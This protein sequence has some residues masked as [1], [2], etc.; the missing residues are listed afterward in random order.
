MHNVTPAKIKWFQKEILKWYSQHGRH[1][2]WRN[3]N[4]T[5]YDKVIAEVLLQ[6]TKAETVQKFYTQFIIDYPNWKSLADADLKDIE[7]YLKP[8]GLYRQRAVRLHNLAVEMVKRNG[9]L[10]RDREELE[11]VPFMGQYIANAVELVVFNQPSPLVDV[12]MARVLERF[13]GPRKMADIRYD[14]YLQELAL[15]VVNHTNTKEINWAI[16]DLAAMVCKSKNMNHNIC[17]LSANCK[18]LVSLS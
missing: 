4:I 11:S 6:R 9:R 15:K 18:Y 12:N 2:T 14:P 17:P 16:L 5:N 13:F 10:P 8:V 1:F 3:K 7:N